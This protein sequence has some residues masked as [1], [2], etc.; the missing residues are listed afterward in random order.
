MKP[1]VLF[2][3]S[4]SELYGADFILLE[5]V[6]ALKDDVRPIVAV[7]GEGDLTRALA[8]EGV[9]VIHTRESVLRR[10]HFKPHKIPGFAWNL[11]RDVLR[12]ARI[13]AEE[14]V[15]LVYSNTGAV[16]TG[17]VAARLCEIP[18]LY[19]IH[20]IIVN[21]GWLAKGIARM[22]LGNAAEVIAVS[23]PVREQLQAYGKPGDPPVRVIHNGLDPARFDE[24][25]DPA[26]LRR[27]LGAGPRDVLYGVIGRVHP[28]KGQRYFV[29]AARLVADV[30]PQARF[31]V[32]GGTFKGY[33]YLIEELKERVEQLAL[34]DRFKILP[35][36]N[37]VP[38]LMRALDVFVLPST[39]PDPLPTVVLEAMAARKPVVATAHGGA[40]EMVLHGETG[41]LAPHHDASAFADAL[42]ELAYDADKRNRLGLAGRKR[43]ETRF[44][45]ER[46]FVEIVRC[47][48]SHLPALEQAVE[49]PKK[50]NPKADVQP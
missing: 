20:E 12:L 25:E 16:I 35:H 32:V 2:V 30:C 45:R 10:V 23:G 24:T 15:Q 18:N 17:A 28:W 11:V 26:D 9:R 44:S 19:H 41:L 39:L 33:E 49:T 46:F 27:E 29:E 8:R 13:I 37:D 42:L 34:A 6:R 7:P 3:H 38:R 40:L 1:A 21:P 31:V 22:I 4:N 47:V 48:R 36:R 50:I 43:L 5:V 14:N